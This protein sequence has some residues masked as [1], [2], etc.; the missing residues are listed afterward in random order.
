MKQFNTGA[1]IWSKRDHQQE[2]WL[3]LYISNA[4]HQVPFPWKSDAKGKG[5][6]ESSTLAS[7]KESG[8]YFFFILCLFVADSDRAHMEN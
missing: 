5:F 8:G 3:F 4:C 6:A 2:D 7:W 1:S